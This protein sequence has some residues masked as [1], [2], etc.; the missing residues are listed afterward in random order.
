MRRGVLDWLRGWYRDSLILWVQKWLAY[1]MEH[2]ISVGARM[3]GLDREKRRER[4]GV[5]M[6]SKEITTER[7]TKSELDKKNIQDGRVGN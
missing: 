5:Y 1:M 2:R 3:D 4:D 7:E 6:K